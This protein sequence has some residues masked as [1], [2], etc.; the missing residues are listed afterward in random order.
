M[1]SSIQSRTPAA[2]AA[3]STRARPRLVLGLEYPL[4]QQG[5][6][7]VLAQEL[8]RRLSPDYEIILVSG[9]AKASD[10]PA[11]FSNCISNRISWEPASTPR[12]ASAARAL[13]A[14]IERLRPDLAHFHFGGTYEW[15]SN[16]FWRC[17]IY[18]L[19]G[20]GVPCMSTNHLAV[21]WLNCGVRPDRPVWQ[22]TLF[23]YAAI[24]SRS[25]LYRRLRLEICV[26]GHDR[27]RLWRSFPF[28]T[29]KVQL[30]YHS[31][32]SA[33]SAEPDLEGRKPVILCVGTIG[34]RKAQGVLAE[35]FSRIASR[36]PEW[37]V[38]LIGR[39]GESMDAEKIRE[40]TL[41]SG[42][43]GR[44]NLLGRLS[45]NDTLQAMK[46]ASIIAMPSLQEGLGLS[47]QEALFHGCVGVGSRAGGIPELIEHEGNGLLVEPGDVAGLSAALDRL[48]SDEALR[49]R[50]RRQAR[51]S[52]LRKGMTAEAMTAGYREIYNGIL[53]ARP[54]DSGSKLL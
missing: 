26:S 28:F 14:R 37:R 52:I 25:L 48:L 39:V 46:T 11:E 38:D 7:E 36:H 20:S 4:M 17:P 23:Q 12:T 53:A 42:L 44:I 30:R 19:A 6:T 27:A 18:W 33:D 54:L 41:R 16:R 10:L 29:Q 22:K 49:Q 51:P 15:R 5:G 34:G 24:A 13:A 9:D 3:K 8:V 1:E 35:A 21:E 40:I 2:A 45:D 50:L 32:L 31:L 43:T 47:V